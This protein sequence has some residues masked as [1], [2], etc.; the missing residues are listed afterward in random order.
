MTRDGYNAFSRAFSF[1]AESENF[2]AVEAT[3]GAGGSVTEACMGGERADDLK[4]GRLLN[5]PSWLGIG[6]EEDMAGCSGGLPGVD[7]NASS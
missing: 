6:I 4:G 2:S 7:V 1:S 3:A 5:V